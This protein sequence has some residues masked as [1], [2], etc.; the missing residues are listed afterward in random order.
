MYIKQGQW[1]DDDANSLKKAI[2]INHTLSDGIVLL[3]QKSNQYR[4][5]VIKN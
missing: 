1:K 5:I 3:G 4:T 2:K